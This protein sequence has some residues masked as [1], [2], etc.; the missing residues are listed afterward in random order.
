[1]LEQ[2][3]LV[4]TREQVDLVALLRAACSQ[5]TTAQHPCTLTAAE[6]VA[7]RGDA[8]RLGEVVANLLDNAIKYSPAGGAVQVRVWCT[9]EEAHLTVTDAGIGIAVAELGQ[10]FER[11]RRGTNADR[12]PIAGT[13]LGLYI[14][15]GIV[16]AHGGQL[17]ATSPGPGQGS[18]FHAVLPLDAGVTS[19]VAQAETA[20]RAGTNAGWPDGPLSVAAAS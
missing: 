10:L 16:S 3:M 2:G 20:V 14:C 1:L 12:H 7:V 5:H 19:T 6:P 9:A 17:W 13:G 8:S 18:T 4:G 11:F 15:R